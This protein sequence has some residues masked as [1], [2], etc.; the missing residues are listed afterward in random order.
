MNKFKEAEKL[1]KEYQATLIAITAEDV[2]SLFDGLFEKYPNFRAIGWTQYVPGFN[3]GEPCEF[4]MDRDCNILT[5]ESIKDYLVGIDESDTMTDE[6]I[7]D[8]A[9]CD[10]GRPK[11]DPQMK[12]DISDV[13]KLISSDISETL[14]GPDVQIIITKTKLTVSSYSCGF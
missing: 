2:K 10:F 8:L 6:E 13:F 7:H 1:K 3:D 14:F 5:N 4:T 11:L 9:V 12:K